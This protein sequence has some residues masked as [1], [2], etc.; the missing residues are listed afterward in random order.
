MEIPKVVYEKKSEN[1][2]DKFYYYMDITFDEENTPGIINLNE[3]P[4]F[5]YIIFKNYYTQILNIFIFHNEKWKSILS[6]LVL[7]KD[8]E[9]D[10]D[11]EKYF[12]INKKQLSLD[13]KCAKPI[14]LL[15][16]YLSQESSTWNTFHISDISFV[17]DLQTS[18]IKEDCKIKKDQRIEFISTDGSKINLD[19]DREN[20][21]QK[22]IEL[23]KNNADKLKIKFFC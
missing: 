6:D 17:K 16:F 14:Q 15:R 21:D 5:D 20:I 3:F 10:E 9:A 13:L 2:D 23:M 8:P 7:M 18:D 22:Y 11:A 4:F 1:I 19:I 12:I